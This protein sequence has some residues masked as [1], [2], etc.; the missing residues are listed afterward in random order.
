MN[1]TASKLS[2]ERREA[3]ARAAR[4]VARLAVVADAKQ[5]AHR[6]N[7]IINDVC[8]Y[9][10]AEAWDAVAAL[11][12]MVRSQGLATNTQIEADRR[13][14]RFQGA[15]RQEPAT[16]AQLDPLRCPCEECGAIP[17]E[18]CSPFCTGQ[19]QLDLD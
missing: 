4:A 7:S 8:A 5:S 2:T 1:W 6:Q 16:I 17:G 11:E 13:A 3:I 10:D 19:D 15:T 12:G 18:P 14:C 9:T